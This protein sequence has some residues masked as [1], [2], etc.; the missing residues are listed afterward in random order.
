MKIAIVYRSFLGATKQYAEWLKGELNADI[1]KF[2][3]VDKAKLALYDLIIVSSG[4]YAGWMPLT[5]FLKHYWDV[6]KNKKTV[7]VAVGAAPAED[8]WSKRSY[9]KIPADIRRQIKYFKLPGKV[10]KAAPAGMEMSQDKLKPV[11]EY[12]KNIGYIAHK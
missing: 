5:S 7:V 2:K 3:A 11:V 12:I 9:E 6:L 10:G 4:T 1:F 8:I